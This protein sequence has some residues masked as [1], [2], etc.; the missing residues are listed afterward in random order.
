MQT[1]NLDPPI[2]Y[3]DG[4]QKKTVIHIRP[5]QEVTTDKE[6]S[7]DDK[8]LGQGVAAAVDAEES[9]TQ[10]SAM[11]KAQCR[12]KLCNFPHDS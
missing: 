2:N 10:T 1:D 3:G 12:E 6:W 8:V 11:L 5:Y 7:T 9:H 4:T